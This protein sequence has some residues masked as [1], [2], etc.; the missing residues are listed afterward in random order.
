LRVTSFN[1]R[2]ISEVIGTILVAA[3]TII[4]GAAIFG[5]VNGQAGSSAQAYGQSV[6]NSV[7][8]LEEKF[9]VVDMSWASTTAA[10]V[11]I[12]NTGKVQ[13]TLL[14]IRFYD[15]M[16]KV[17]LLYNYSTIS[18]STVN[19]IHD[20]LGT[21]SSKCG[22]SATL[23]ESPTITGSGS[24]SAAISYTSTIQLTIP[25]TSASPTGQTCPSF[26]QVDTTGDVYYLAVVGTFGNTK[27]YSQVG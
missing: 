21:S 14:Q 4:A 16:K 10:T 15:S 25:P 12:Y 9:T 26:G 13:L 19:R 17:N 22:I 8:Y 20:L 18:G 2:A 11:W 3:M 27:V 23:Y 5:Y 24:F 7:Q 1:R 6:G